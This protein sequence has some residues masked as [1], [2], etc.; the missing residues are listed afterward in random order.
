MLA[1]SAG[2]RQELELLRAEARRRRVKTEHLLKEVLELQ[3]RIDA[4]LRHE[5]PPPVRR[6]PLKK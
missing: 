1:D 6:K 5:D 2:L 3:H 4:V